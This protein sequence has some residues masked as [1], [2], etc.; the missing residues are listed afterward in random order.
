MKIIIQGI[1][2]LILGFVLLAGFN[3]IPQ[4][5]EEYI[6][7]TGSY[8]ENVS[9]LEYNI[10]RPLSLAEADSLYLTFSE[11]EVFHSGDIVVA[12]TASNPDAVIFY[13]TDGSLPTVSSR[14]Y[15]SPVRLAAGGRQGANVLRAIAVYGD[16]STPALT[17]TYFQGQNR[18][19]QNVLVFSLS[20]DPD[21]LF[22]H[23]N[24]ILVPGIIRENFIRE[25]PGHNV[26]PTDP[27]NFNIRGRDGE[28]PIYVEVISD[29]GERLFS[30]A[31]GVRAHGRWSRAYDQRSLRLIARREYSPH[32]GQFRF[33][34]FPWETAYDGTEIDR[35]DTLILR[36][37]A[38]DRAHGMLRNEVGSLL[39]AN[40]GFTAVT[41]V[42]PAAVYINGRYYGFAWLQVRFN[43]QYLQH[44]FNAPSRNFDIVGIG[45]AVFETDDPQLIAELYAKSE[46]ANKNLRDNDIFSQLE[47][48][49]D[50]DNLLFYYAF[51]IFMGQ[52]DWPHNNL[53]RWRYT[54]ETAESGYL[55]G[56]W[57]YLFFD[58]DWTLG[59]Y[60]D[61][62]RKP[63]FDRVLVADRSFRWF[64][65][66]DARS[67]LLAAILRRP[68]MAQ[69]FTAIMCH[70]SKNIVNERTVTEAINYLFGQSRHEIE[71]SISAG[72]YHHWFTLHRAVEN[73]EAMISFA[74]N[75]HV[76]IYGDLQRKFGFSPRGGCF[77]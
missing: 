19:F 13:T 54:G 1:A 64:D 47:A 41:P 30:Q 70:I 24:G 68:D 26:I 14:V 48:I 57:R 39:L 16:Y 53:R 36:N 38:N 9:L 60:G 5:Y 32:S 3:L 17:K 7:E 42:R 51:Q 43:E 66:D 31:A 44:L 52:E 58:L 37:S 46:F 27:A 49:V 21:Y 71:H 76:Q 72:K 8:L 40:A 61:T 20:T 75:R 45:E 55:D 67:P 34:F 12:I 33:D 62:Y 4:E 59:L 25:N 11:T 23:H 77:C 6:E 50:I 22:C 73:H 15:S 69:R 29:S 2:V 63:T 10:A 35:Y 74:R 65:T 18:R 28:R 56:R